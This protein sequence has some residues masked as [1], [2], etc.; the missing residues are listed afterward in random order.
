MQRSLGYLSLCALV[1]LSLSLPSSAETISLYAT[2][3]SV[4][5][6][7]QNTS[8]QISGANF[9]F[10]GEDRTGFGYLYA[11]IGEVIRLGPFIDSEYEVYEYGGVPFGNTSHPA[12]FT[13]S[14]GAAPMPAA[15]ARPGEVTVPGTIQ[16]TYVGCLTASQNDVTGCDESA[17]T[18]YLVYINLSGELSYRFRD[19]GDGAVAIDDVSFSGTT[20]PEPSSLALLFIGLLLPAARLLTHPRSKT[21]ILP[22]SARRASSQSGPRMPPLRDYA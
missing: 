1:L 12:T 4:D 8:Y 5:A 9:S 19:A 16:G 21:A 6:G 2:Y 7:L 20:T 3:A 14:A 13:G 11:D 22:E 15:I 18:N 10:Y 17:T